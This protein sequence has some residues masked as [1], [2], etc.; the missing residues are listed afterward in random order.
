[1]PQLHVGVSDS[2][3]PNLDPAREV[4]ARIGAELHLA[5]EPTPESILGVA[6]DADALLATYAKITA[7]MIPEMKKCRIISRFG[8]GVSI[9]DIPATSKAGIVV[10]GVPDYGID[11]VSDHPLAL[12]LAL[13]RK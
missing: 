2:V 12:L 9:F 10:R 6:R 13:V 7:D 8:S 5:K 1:M 4:L 3:F 11:E